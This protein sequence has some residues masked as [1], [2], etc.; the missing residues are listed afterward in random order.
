MSWIW[1]V[2]GALLI[3][4]VASVLFGFF[5]WRPRAQKRVA[6]ATHALAQELHGRPPL[7]IGPAQCRTSDLRDGRALTGLGV[8]A[9]TEHAVLFSSG[10]R[11]AVLSRDGLQVQ[12]KGTTLD[13]ASQVPPGRLVVQLPDAGAWAAALAG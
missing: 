2:L 11:V 1:I 13:L 6:A 12:V 3:A 10:E 8:L 7:L 5:F 9:L 4:L